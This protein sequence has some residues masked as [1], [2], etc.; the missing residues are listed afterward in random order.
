MIRRG[1]YSK[2]GKLCLKRNNSS[3]CFTILPVSNR[4]IYFFFHYLLIS[5]GVGRTGVFIVLDALLRQLRASQELS[6]LAFLRRARTQRRRLVGTLALY[7]FAHEAM[8]EAVAAGETDIP[9]QHLSRWRR[10]QL[11]F[12]LQ[13]IQIWESEKF[14]GFLALRRYISGLQTS[15][16]ADENSVP[17]RLLDRQF[18]LATPPLRSAGDEYSAALAP[19]SLAKSRSADFLPREATR[20]VL[21]ANGAASAAGVADD[22]VNA[23]W[24]PGFFLRDEFLLTQHPLESTWPEFWR[25]VWEGRVRTVVVLSAVQPTVNVLVVHTRIQLN[26]LN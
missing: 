13:H 3:L 22:Y 24:L 2:N 4:K 8:A 9:R 26:P 5:N 6:P 17:W 19:C 10:S 18:S 20:V 12:N 16:T 25:M 11:P 14:W 15:Y 7:R 23:S 1:G 21:E